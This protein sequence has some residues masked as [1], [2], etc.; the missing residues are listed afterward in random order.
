MWKLIVVHEYDEILLELISHHSALPVSIDLYS[1]VTALIRKALGIYFQTNY[2]VARADTTPLYSGTNIFYPRMMYD[3]ISMF[4]INLFYIE[5]ATLELLIRKV[6]QAISYRDEANKTKLLCLDSVKAAFTTEEYEKVAGH[7][8]KSI[9]VR[10]LA[11]APQ[12][13]PPPKES[14]TDI[15]NLLSEYMNADALKK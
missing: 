11:M 4:G 3:L 5:I 13:S 1:K 2:Y 8:S 14:E 7:S 9:E 15:N 6:Y 12:N 10:E